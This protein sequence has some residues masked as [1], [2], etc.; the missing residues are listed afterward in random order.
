MVLEKPKIKYYIYFAEIV[1]ILPI[2]NKDNDFKGIVENFALYTCNL[3][4]S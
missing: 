4:D 2:V 3:F 1:Y